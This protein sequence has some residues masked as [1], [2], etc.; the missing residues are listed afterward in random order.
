ML[1]HKFLLY[2][3]SYLIIVSARGKFT[4]KVDHDNEFMARIMD[5]VP[6]HVYENTEGKIVEEIERLEPV[7]ALTSANKKFSGLKDEKEWRLMENE[8]N[9]ELPVRIRGNHLK[10]RRQK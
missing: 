5:V 2:L 7:A 8:L 3:S 9:E 10:I 1:N 4:G 6:L